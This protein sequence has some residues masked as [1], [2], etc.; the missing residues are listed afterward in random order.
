LQTSF[1]SALHKTGN[2]CSKNNNFF[3]EPL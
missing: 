1:V 2:E 3:K